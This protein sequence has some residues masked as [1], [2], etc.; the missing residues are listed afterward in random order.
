MF[1]EKM[2]TPAIP[3]RVYTLCKIVEKKPISNSDLK[4]KM[5]PDFLN[6]NTVYYAD[7]RNAAEQ[8]KL[9][10]ISDNMISLAVDASI[11]KSIDAMRTYINSMLEEFKNGQFYQVTSA[12][13]N[14]GS[15]ALSGDRNIVNL[16]QY[17]TN[18]LNRPVDAMAMRA[19]RF[20][21][22]FLG[23]GYL[24]NMFIIPNASIFLLDLINNS[25]FQKNHRYS[26]GDFIAQIT[27][28]CNIIVDTNSSNNT[29]NYGVSNGLRTLHESGNIKL[30]HIL[31]QEDIWNLYLLKAHEIS[32]T[33]TNIT[34]CK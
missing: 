34:F 7:Y 17:F 3:E 20:W 33:V 13:F 8:L 6:N 29:L 4:E 21:V 10:S 31:D 12:Y 30:E 15:K 16:A 28:S 1:L 5:E 22:S 14:L 26:F 25:N 24:H 19:W 23:F 18:Q 9:I 27:P 2:M 32:T 11:I